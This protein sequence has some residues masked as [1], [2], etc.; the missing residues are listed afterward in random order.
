MSTNNPKSSKPSSSKPTSS[1]TPTQ[2]QSLP[3]P[4]S[5]SSSSSS[6]K[7]SPS[8]SLSSH[9]AMVE[10]K[11]RILTSLSKL[12]DRDTHQIAV[13]ELHSVIASLA[14]DSLPMFLN[15]LYDSSSDPKPALKKESLRLLAL[16]AT[17][18]PDPSSAHLPK[19]IAHIARR[20]KDADS[21]VRDAC[22]DA[23][24]SLAAQYL[25]ADGEAVAIFV[26]PLFEAMAEQNKA[27]QAGAAMCLA[28]MVESARETPVAAFQKLCPRICKYLANPNFLAKAAVLSVVSSLSQVV[29]IAPQSLPALMQSI[30]GCLENSDW[31]TRKAAADTLSVMASHSSHLVADGAASTI[32]A[33]ESCRFDKVKPVRDSM[34]EALQQWKK[35]AGKG[36]GASEDPKAASHDGKDSE[37]TEP[38]EKVELKKLNPSDRKLESSRKDASMSSSPIADSLSKVKGS[39]ISD[40]TV[41]IL[42][43]KAPALSD[44]E[45]NPEFF[46]KLETRGSGDLPVEVVLPRRFLHSSHSQGDESELN[47]ADSRCISN[48]NGAPGG[49]SNDIHGAIGAKKV[50]VYTNK[51]Q[52]ADDYARDKWAEQR[53]FRG[54]DL[55]SRAFDVDDRIDINQRDATS[56]RGGFNRGD[57]H[58]EGH[59]GNWLAIQRQLSQLERQQANLMAMLQDF[60]GGSHDSMVTLENRVRG[61]ERIVED[62]ARDLAISSGRRG[63]NLMMGFEGTSGRTLG[64]YNGLPDYSSSKLG[65]GGDGRIPYTE[66]F[67]SSDGISSG[68]RGRDFPWRS[69]VSDAWDAYAYGASRNGHLN[70]RRALS[71][72]SSDGRSPRAELDSDQV[73]NRRAWDKG[74]G[75]RLGEGP[76]ARSVWQASKDEAT[77]EA[78]RVAGEDN[79]TSRA[80]TR[81]A[82]PE[83]NAE[84]LTE[85]NPGQERG[86]L[87]ASWSHAM[88][89]LHVGDMDSAYAEVLSTGDDRLLVKLMDRSGPVVDQL[90]NEVASE[91][92]HAV[93]QFLLD[94]SS[95]DIGLCWTQQLE[96]MIN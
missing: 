2:H 50:D 7:P 24:G 77:L 48:N 46:Q 78:I 94:Q 3:P 87:W 25:R 45:L 60:M 28:K 92:L 21:S 1:N 86:P 75:P 29:A 89:A 23:V 20:L 76:S 88:D 80:A 27:V 69:D 96:S 19:I 30:H 42:K 83:L 37:S 95:I 61:L 74:P 62:M 16:A 49:E 55:K 32:T 81:V 79:G 26:R 5:S 64:K 41:G 43:K 13:D 71:G 40:K 35:I 9:L 57:G 34:T 53:V 65:R 52:D 6:S 66:R 12:S 18:H 84:A 72:A 59:K 8:P 73:G 90:S 31:A 36:D 22:R 4:P 33:L 93:G 70:S 68:V 82:I 67:L 56:V 38:L 47:D 58:S 11:Q 63:S 54:K 10:L 51:L 14:A 15:C 85:D 17:S 91:V 39:S 44:K